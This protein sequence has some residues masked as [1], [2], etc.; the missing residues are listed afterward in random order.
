MENKS[1]EGIF[2]I[3]K[4]GFF[5]EKKKAEKSYTFIKINFTCVYLCMLRQLERRG[6][7]G[8]KE[9]EGGENLL[10]PINFVS[11]S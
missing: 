6:G 7:R 3:S 4:K 2:Y 10:G 1:F 5:L 11:T 9:E 8:E